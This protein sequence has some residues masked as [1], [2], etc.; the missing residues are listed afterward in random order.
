MTPCWYCT[1][2]LHLICPRHVRRWVGSCSCRC[3]PAAGQPEPEDMADRWDRLVLSP[4]E[5]TPTTVAGQPEPD[6]NPWPDNW[7]EQGMHTPTAGQSEPCPTC[8]GH[9]GWHVPATITAEAF[10]YCPDCTGADT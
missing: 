8:G 4:D 10:W 7:H 9:N 1:H 3:V 2:R 6:D 5:S